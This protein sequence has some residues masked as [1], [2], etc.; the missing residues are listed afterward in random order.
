MIVLFLVGCKSE[1]GASAPDIAIAADTVE[2][3]SS[4]DVSDVVSAGSDFDETTSQNGKPPCSC[5]PDD[6]CRLCYEHIGNCCYD[7]P[8][9]YGEIVR[10]SENCDRSGACKACCSECIAKSCDQLKADFDCPNL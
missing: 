8:T 5:G 9:I 1:N 3:Q 2:I 10:L 7:D 4:P 6:N